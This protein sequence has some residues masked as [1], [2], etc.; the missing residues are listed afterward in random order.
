MKAGKNKVFVTLI[1]IFGATACTLIYRVDND[2][3]NGLPQHASPFP[4]GQQ[5]RDIKKC[6]EI[7]YPELLCFDIL[8]WEFSLDAVTFFTAPL[9]YRKKSFV[10]SVV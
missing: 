2:I 7:E 1:D 6:P 4:F 3:Q 10:K 9:F 8:N 5:H